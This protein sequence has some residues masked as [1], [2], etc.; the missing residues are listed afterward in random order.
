MKVQTVYEYLKLG[1]TEID[2]LKDIVKLYQP[3]ELPNDMEHTNKVYV[4]NTSDSE[5]V[6]IKQTTWSDSS[7]KNILLKDKNLSNFNMRV[8]GFDPS[9]IDLTGKTKLHIKLWTTDSYQLRVKLVD[10]K[11]AYGG[12]DDTETEIN[13]SHTPN[14]WNDIDLELSDF[15]NVKN[16]NQFILSSVIGDPAEL[17]SSNIIL[18]D[19]YF[20]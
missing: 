19:I 3:L 20:Y 1:L 5:S 8:L 6:K 9:V 7:Y 14:Q 11:G 18:G 2:Q 10:W 16:V 17:K 15:P 13:I 4:H 12:G